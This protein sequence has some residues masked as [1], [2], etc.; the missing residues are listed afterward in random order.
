MLATLAAS[1]LVVPGFSSVEDRIEDMLSTLSISDPI[2]ANAPLVDRD[3]RH[4]F[5]PAW[6]TRAYALIEERAHE[7]GLH[8]VAWYT[9]EE[10]L[11]SREQREPRLPW[12]RPLRY[13][14]L[15]VQR[16]GQ[17]DIRVD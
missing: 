11:A 16:N 12:Q 4:R 5:S 7:L 17:V 14:V 10:A 2:L 3:D 8:F 15:E 1:A 13:P 6:T 9:A